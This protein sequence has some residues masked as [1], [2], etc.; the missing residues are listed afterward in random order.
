MTPLVCSALILI[1]LINFYTVF[2]NNYYLK[3]IMLK[4]NLNLTIFLQ[5]FSELSKTTAYCLLSR[6]VYRLEL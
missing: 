1:N 2:I 3:G 5:T 4:D 6:T